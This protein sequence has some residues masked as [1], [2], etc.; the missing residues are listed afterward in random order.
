MVKRQSLNSAHSHTNCS[1]LRVVSWEDDTFWTYFDKGRQVTWVHLWRSAAYP[2][3]LLSYNKAHYA[4]PC[5]FTVSSS[6]KHGF[7]YASRSFRS[8]VDFEVRLHRKQQLGTGIC[9]NFYI[10][11]SDTE[12]LTICSPSQCDRGQGFDCLPIF[13]SLCNF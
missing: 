7:L 3:L 11:Y 2:L 5:L 10:T 8:R 12:V 4:P 13:Y 6:Q 1:K 9:F